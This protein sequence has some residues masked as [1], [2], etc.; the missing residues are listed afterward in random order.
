[1]NKA[2]FSLNYRKPKSDYNDDDE[3]FICIR[4]NLSNSKKTKSRIKQI[5]SGIRWEKLQS[6]LQR[7]QITVMQEL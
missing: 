7:L 3:L 2:T 1:M 5:S 6:K 4:K